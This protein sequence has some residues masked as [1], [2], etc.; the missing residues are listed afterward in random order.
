VVEYISQHI[1]PKA[2]FEY[3]DT[4]CRQV[5]NRIPNIRQFASSHDLIFFVS[6]KKSSNGKMLFSECLNVNPN[7]HLIDS[8]EE[9]DLSLLKNINSIGICGATSTP[10]WAMEEVSDFLKQ[11]LK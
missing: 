11:S 4:I 5:A 9:I 2:H 6:G 8:K 7:S 10:K 1:S 3:F